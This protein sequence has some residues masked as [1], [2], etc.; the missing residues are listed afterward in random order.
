[1]ET[2]VRFYYSS[3]SKDN[4]FKSKM[5]EVYKKQVNDLELLVSNF[6]VASAIIHYDE[7][8]PH[9]HI[10]GV[11]IKYK[12][13]N[14]MEKQVGKSD[15][16]TKE[17]L[18]RLQDKM[19]TLCIEEFNQVYR[20]DSLKKKQKGR[21]R[22]IHV[23]DMDNYIEMKK[24]IEK[25]T[26]TL[27]QANK[28]SSELKQNSKDIKDKIDKLKVSRLNKDNYIISKEDKDSFI[29]FIEQ[30]DNINKE[31]DKIQTL[32]NTLVNAHEQLKDKNNKIK[33]LTENNEALNLRVKTLNDTIREKDNEISFLK[34]KINDLKNTLEYWKDKFEKLISFLHSKLHSWYDKDDK[35]I[36]VVN[37]MYED[38]VLDDDDIEDLDLNKEKDDYER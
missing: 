32:S 16:F 29:D 21:N 33:T 12:N 22:D 28:K 24:Q 4:K 9:L 20:L 1:M 25:N 3:D 34:S 17:S 26:E 23:S 31:Y 6:K 11:P 10:V 18:I 38:N 8:S 36:D 37:D 2:E 19:R 13:K 15:V 30:V 7:T 5:S 35:Y 14:G 27:K